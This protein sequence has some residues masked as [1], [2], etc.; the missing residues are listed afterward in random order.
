MSRPFLIDAHSHI[1]FSAYKDDAAEVI[2]RAERE[3]TWMLAVGS[4]IDTSRRAVEYA[5]RF[6]NVWAVI[7][8]HPI[9]L[10]DTHVDLAEVGEEGRLRIAKRPLLAFLYFGGR[11][12]PK[13]V[14]LTADHPSKLGKQLGPSFS[15]S[16]VGSVFV[17]LLAHALEEFAPSHLS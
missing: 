3:G 14:G 5:E 7:G 17:Q 16:Y 12:A 9:H 15:V 8:L 10:V 1:N 13:H 2:A 11:S 6:T 4:Q